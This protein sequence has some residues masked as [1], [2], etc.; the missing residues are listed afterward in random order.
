MTLDGLGAATGKMDQYS[1]NMVI[2]PHGAVEAS[3]MT[4]LHNPSGD[5]LPLGR[6]TS[7]LGKGPTANV[8]GSV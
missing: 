8:L 5:L 2:A 7:T 1:A 3:E 4:I 6:K